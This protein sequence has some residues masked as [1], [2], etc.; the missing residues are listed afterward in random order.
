MTTEKLQAANAAA[1]ALDQ[2]E[3]LCRYV[4]REGQTSTERIDRLAQQSHHLSEEERARL[5]SLIFEMLNNRAAL[6]AAAF[7]A[8]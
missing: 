5:S 7:A 8:L 3:N 2:A 4:I 6:A 1:Q